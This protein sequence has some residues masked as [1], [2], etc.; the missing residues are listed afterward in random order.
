M[1]AAI[2]L[3]SDR[4]ELMV[5]D[6]AFPGG[7][8]PDGGLTVAGHS[9]VPITLAQREMLVALA[10][11]DPHAI[12]LASLV[13]NAA[14]GPMEDVGDAAVLRA[15]VEA[16]ALFL[17]GAEV[18]GPLARTSLL[19]GR[20]MG[21]AAARVAA[22]EADRIAGALAAELVTP[23]AGGASDDGW[24]SISYEPAATAGPSGG[25]AESVERVRDRLAAQLIARD[26]VPLGP[27]LLAALLRP[28]AAEQ[29]GAAEKQEAAPAPGVGRR[30]P[31]IA[32]T[33]IKSAEVAVDAGTSPT[34]ICTGKGTDLDRWRTSSP[35]LGGGSPDA[36]G[37]GVVEA[38]DGS[39]PSSAPPTPG[40]ASAQPECALAT[41]TRA[42]GRPA[43]ADRW[44]E[45]ASST[46][47]ARPSPHVAGTPT[48]GTGGGHTG[49]LASSDAGELVRQSHATAPAS[50]LT[51]GAS[52]PRAPLGSA[53]RVPDAQATWHVRP[54][55]S[56]AG[57]DDPG[58]RELVAPALGRTRIAVQPV[59]ALRADGA[60]AAAEL[61]L[62]AA[63]QALHR[64]ADLRG[65][66]R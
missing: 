27:E 24:T 66:P 48:P 7:A 6:T 63:A 43:A 30:D 28:G 53:W 47:T 55:G 56:S 13:A 4:G 10:V 31:F 42:S 41:A 16:V 62:D 17:A 40:R 14:A 23:P 54:S 52:G 58:G 11:G 60:A 22:S 21:P 18:P 46:V 2:R 12:R 9:V 29:Q 51:T 39:P 49:R 45:A 19:V 50:T 1:T 61:D 37:A 5:G 35:A 36:G 25:A 44:W 34:P 57:A 59:P 33:R 8:A 20:V 38:P 26:A 65:L 32:P 64:A 15:A 3:L